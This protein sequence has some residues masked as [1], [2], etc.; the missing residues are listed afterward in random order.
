MPERERRPPQRVPPEPVPPDRDRDPPPERDPLD[1]ADEDIER[2]E[3]HVD[4]EE[5][6]KE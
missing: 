1:D 3:E 5:P 4:K 2:H 6:S